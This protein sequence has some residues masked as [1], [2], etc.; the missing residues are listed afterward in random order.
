MKDPNRMCLVALLLCLTAALAWGQLYSGS[1]T[2]VVSDP[3]GASIPGAKVS[4]TDEDK[5]FVFNSETDA[6]G[7]YLF[8][9]VPPA[10]YKISVTAEGFQI[11]TRSKV[12][13]D[14]SQN[15]TID[16]A[17]PLSTAVAAIDITGEAPILATED[18]STGQVVDRRFVNDLP[19]L[20]RDVT[21]LAYLA[22]GI[23]S[24]FNGNPWGGN[25]G[26]AFASSGGR[27]ATADV[28]MDGV[29]T[30]NYEQNGGTLVVSYLPTPDAIQEFRVQTSQFSAEYGFTGSTVVNMVM[31]SGTNS[32]H[33]SAYEYLRNN[34]LDSNNFFNNESGTPLAGLHRN[35][36]GGTMGGP[37]KRNKTFFFFDYDGLRQSSSTGGSF[38]VP[39]AVERTGNFGELCGYAGGTFDAN[40]RC[41][42][43]AGQ[44]W[45]PYSGTYSAAA[46]GAVRS[47]YIPFNNLATY[48]S[49]GNANLNG[50]GYQLPSRPGNLIDPVAAKMIQAFPLPN[51]NVGNANYAYYNNWVG[52]GANVTNRDQWDL[53][54]DHSFSDK[55]L[56]SGKF[57]WQHIFNHS[58]NCFG[59]AED[60][61]S[62]GPDPNHS[63]LGALNLNHTFSPTLLL[64]VSYGYNRWW[65]NE[66]TA[67]G[68][69][70]NV[71]PI[72]TL[73]LPS[74]MYASGLNVFPAVTVGDAY[75]SV[76]G[77]SVGTWP[78]TY[79]I[80]GQDTHQLLATM[81]WIKGSHEVKFGAEGRMH[82]VN[83]DLPGP[84]TGSYYYDYSSTSQTPDSATGGDAMASFLTGVGMHNNGMYE[85]PSAFASQNL[86]WGGFVQDNWKIRRGLTVNLGLRYDLT[87]PRTERY[88]HANWVDPS[89][90]SP[91]Q[92]PGLGT[93][94]GGE[95]FASATDRYVYNP[96][97]TNF[98]PRAGF[99]WQ[100]HDK[101]VIRGG[102]GIYYS[103]SRTAVAGVGTTGTGHQG[104]VQDTPWLTSYQNDGATPWGRLSDPWP[105]TGPNLPPGNSLGLL[106]D[107]GFGAYGP[108][109]NINAIPYE[110]S[111]SL[112]V[113]RELPWSI[114]LDASYVGKKG[115]HLYFGNS[116][117]YD[118][119]GPQ[120]EQYSSSQIAAML[121]YVPNPFYGIITNPNSGLSSPTIQAYQLLRR[122]PQ[123][124]A[125]GS[126][127]QPVANSIYNGLQ[128]RI[129]KRFSSGIQFLV[130]YTFSKSLDDASASTNA[131]YTGATSL[132]DPN[133]FYLERSVSLFDITNVLQFSH[134]YELPFGRGKKVGSNWNSVTQAFLGGWQLN[135]IWTFDSGRPLTPGLLG[136]Y[137]LPTYGPQRPDLL[138]RPERNTGSN[139]MTQYF[140]NPDVFVAPTP[141]AIG[142]APRTLPWIRTPGQRN[143]NLSLFKAFQLSKLREGMS[144]EYRIQTLNAFNHPL[145]A[146]PNMTVGSDSFGAVT[147][148]ANTP[149]EVEM[150]LRLS[151]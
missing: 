115:T 86:Q 63:Y 42:A 53:K 22:P 48:M 139:W 57:S 136:G 41:S 26:N 35:N 123:F 47:A 90:V 83:F 58:W 121:S 64:T 114:L 130:T 40:G 69:Y 7:R 24:P 118:A 141:Y 60:P 66:S 68:D 129:Q 102:Y 131:W 142:N 122:F 71:N 3:S 44:L 25:Y 36:F 125:F 116:G 1:A 62:A 56:L 59:N 20:G 143:S 113:Q 51:L 103:T 23:V 128:M 5:G 19:L 96:D 16:F 70:P 137:S 106:N 135:G 29:S 109:K 39:S 15:V 9:S 84:T 76:N 138:G 88:N 12:R 126:D 80:R 11:Q 101:T 144:L 99:A 92:V 46:G 151:F 18:A 4:L 31:R 73:G 79:I 105:I 32:Y 93:L 37:I 13:I 124:T 74:Y 97:Y 117:Q 43:A 50:T 21:N 110:Q 52:S 34:K 104:Y 49:P 45:D 120:I 111:W 85:V 55:T 8:P 145:F 65:E 75:T 17:L 72:Q 33:G 95:V 148:Q 107:I 127:D 82:R 91:L 134:V 14:V 112:G 30:T 10:S 140:A 38:G 94:Y 133:R 61:C 2:G 67:M 87:L 6:A 28:L 149:R 132:Q 146:G 77:T 150:G 54:I 119:L 81:T 100:A 27:A 78:W 89:V 147:S 98:Q 108:I